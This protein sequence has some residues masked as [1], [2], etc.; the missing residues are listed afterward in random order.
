MTVYAD[1]SRTD[2]SAYLAVIGP[3]GVHSVRNFTRPDFPAEH[4]GVARIEQAAATIKQATTGNRGMSSLLLAAVVAAVVVVVNQ[5]M[6]TWAEGRLLAAWFSLWLVAF[7]VL[8]VFAAPVRRAA[9]ALRATARAW[10]QHRLQ[11]AEDERL[12]DAAARDPRVMS[13][14]MAIMDASTTR[15]LR[16]QFS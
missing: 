3:F 8:A 12:W 14:L 11:A 4:E 6:S 2:G 1:Q 10:N 7:A 9:V 5:V 15:K 16:R 13:E